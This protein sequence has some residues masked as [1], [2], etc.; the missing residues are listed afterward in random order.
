VISRNAVNNNNNKNNNVAAVWIQH[1]QNDRTIPENKPDIIIRDN[2]KGAHMPVNVAISGDRNV[3]KK[4]DKMLKYKDLRVE[5]QRMWNVKIKVIPVIT[6]ATGTI[7]E[8]LRQCL[9]NVTG[10]NEITELR[11]RP[12]WALHSHCGKC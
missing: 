4:E 3:M 5:I 8:S 2:V 10:K 7:S 6:G 1:V 12:Y 11:K 9:S